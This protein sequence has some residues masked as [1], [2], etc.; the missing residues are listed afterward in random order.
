MDR[1]DNINGEKR[2]EEF[3]QNIPLTL[4]MLASSAYQRSPFGRGMKPLFG[5]TFFALTVYPQK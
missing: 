2:E 5:K 4:P 1:A 3:R